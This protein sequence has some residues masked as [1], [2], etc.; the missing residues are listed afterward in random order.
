MRRS[1]IF[2][3]NELKSQLL[4]RIHTC[5]LHIDKII[6]NKETKKYMPNSMGH[7]CLWI[8]IHDIEGWF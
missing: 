5:G 8:V 6:T 7:S 1:G 4:R 3:I 2:G